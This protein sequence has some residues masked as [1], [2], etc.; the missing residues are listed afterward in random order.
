[1]AKFQKYASGGGFNPVRV[2]RENV[3]KILQQGARDAKLLKQ[4]AE[5][6]LKEAKRQQD[7]K[8]AAF[9]FEQKQKARNEEIAQ[10]NAQQQI[11]AAQNEQQVQI[12]E[13]QNPGS[14][15]SVL[16][17]VAQLSSTASQMYD[18]YKTE[19]DKIT[20]QNDINK[21]FSDPEYRAKVDEAAMSMS[22]QNNAVATEAIF[23]VNVAD[24]V[25]GDK[26]PVAQ[27]A[28]PIINLS[29]GQAE[30]YIQGKVMEYP[31]YI[32][33]FFSDPNNSLTIGGQNYDVIQISKD[34]DL[35]S[36]GLSELRT[37]FFEERG[38]D[39]LSVE[40]MSKGL[41]SIM[42]TE[43]QLLAANADEYIETQRASSTQS[44]NMLYAELD[45][46][47]DL[48]SLDAQA[49]V[50]QI[51]ARLLYGNAGN[52][53]ATLEQYQDMVQSVTN[54]VLKEALESYKIN[55]KMTIMDYPRR[56]R[57]IRNER[58]D[59]VIQDENR[60]QRAAQARFVANNREDNVLETY[61]Q[62]LKEAQAEGP[63][64][65]QQVINSIEEDQRIRANGFAVS[66]PAV[67]QLTSS[68]TTK[69]ANGWREQF[70][71]D[72]INGTL[73]EEQADQA[74]TS[75]DRKEYLEAY[76]AQQDKRYG[77]NYD[78]VKENLDAAAKQLTEI[79]GVKRPVGDPNPYETLIKKDLRNRFK[80]KFDELMSAGN[81]TAQQASAEALTYVEGLVEQG[82]L[83]TPG[84]IYQREISATKSSVT[85]LNPQLTSA[86]RGPA[87][88]SR[89]DINKALKQNPKTF[90]N[91]NGSILTEA[92]LREAALTYDAGDGSF[93]IPE[94]VQYVHSLSNGNFKPI[95]LINAQIDAYNVAQPDQSKHI[96]RLE[97]NDF[98]KRLND[99]DPESLSIFSDVRER[100]PRRL[101]RASLSTAKPEERQRV[102]SYS[103]LKKD[104]APLTPRIVDAIIGKESGGDSTVLNQSGSGAI[105]LGQVMPE[106][107][108]PWTNTY[109][110]YRMTPEEFRYDPAAQMT[111][112]T[113]KV[114]DIYQDQLTAGYDEDTAIRRTASIWYSGRGELY[115][116]T[117]PQYWDGDEYPSID[118]YTQYILDTVKGTN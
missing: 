75:E 93:F 13:S 77:P 89:A 116:N 20:K 23:E 49:Q 82:L 27:L 31:G 68:Y 63:I 78:Q 21:Y 35:Y 55:D 90:Q 7:N 99:M 81:L 95:D 47:I 76:Q 19:Q 58:T 69:S 117:N 17:S 74:P 103:K 5:S 29:P 3:N 56:A 104:L 96:E 91:I 51:W 11:A 24:A 73:T 72:S 106:N 101:T 16:S 34:P 79:P 86:L 109:L 108:G 43:G 66:D 64:A 33:N 112:I 115:N 53:S 46:S 1:M 38:M 22:M 87:A 84:S 62:R 28:N 92:Q 9:D 85:F 71:E 110:G 113:G 100:S 18:T 67:E 94:S 25:S 105:G 61:T 111:V 4:F 114:N 60:V 70:E 10:Y 8:N 83:N 45:N 32:A 41:Q 14:L 26:L 36:R 6:D 88:V 15:A 80:V 102:L 52:F 40:S 97:P 118:S 59:R 107:V 57:D 2:S 48:N 44:A 30:A 37:R 98:T 50:P 42:S 65:V 39:Q 12:R 54:P